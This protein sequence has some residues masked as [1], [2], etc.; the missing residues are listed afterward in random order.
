MIMT[1]GRL[2]RLL[3][4]K[5]REFGH[6]MTRREFAGGY[7]YGLDVADILDEDGME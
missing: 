6:N 3:Q 1:R 4:R 2:C 5:E 7:T